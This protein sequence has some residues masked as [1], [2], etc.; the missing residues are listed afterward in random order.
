M[1]AADTG[2]IIGTKSVTL[3]GSAVV[4]KGGTVVASS[5]AGGS[6]ARFAV[7][8]LDGA[9]EASTLILGI[10]DLGTARALT[11]AGNTTPLTISFTD[12]KILK[13]RGTG[14]PSTA[15]A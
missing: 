5:T 15:L 11:G 4:I 12:N 13:F 9:N 6:T 2:L 1:D 7:L 14:D 10:L 3:S 8:T